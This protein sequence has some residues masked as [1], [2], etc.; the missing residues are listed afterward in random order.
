MH[1]EEHFTPC[2]SHHFSTTMFA[3]LCKAQNIQPHAYGAPSL[4]LDMPAPDAP[5]VEN[6][7][8]QC[9]QRA[10]LM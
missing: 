1:R 9:G 7:R 6:A 4:Q 10:L 5:G 3:Y 2:S 8:A